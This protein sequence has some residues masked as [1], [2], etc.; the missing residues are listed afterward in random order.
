[1][2]LEVFVRVGPYDYRSFNC[3]TRTEARKVAKHWA[4]Y[5]DVDICRI[6][7]GNRLISDYRQDK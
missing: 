4:R 2:E 3:K 7:D 5:P 6:M 1:M